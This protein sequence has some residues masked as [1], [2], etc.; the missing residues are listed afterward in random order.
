[1]L[2]PLGYVFH[3]YR[4]SKDCDP[5]NF[6]GGFC[7]DGHFAIT[8][9]GYVI[10]PLNL[11]CISHMDLSHGPTSHTHLGYLAVNTQQW[12]FSQITPH[13]CAKSEGTISRGVRG[14]RQKTRKNSVKLVKNTK[15]RL[16]IRKSWNFSTWKFSNLR[17][18]AEKRNSHTPE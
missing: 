14:L 3:H 5:R 17:K 2:A 4:S 11:C 18:S 13:D 1:M 7:S 8:Y 6:K 15:N 10:V 9:G 12:Y 16:K